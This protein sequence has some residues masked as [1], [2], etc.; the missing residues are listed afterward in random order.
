MVRVLTLNLW[1]PDAR[2]ADDARQIPF[3]DEILRRTAALP[4]VAAAGLTSDLPLGGSDSVLGF[5]I[6]GRPDA[7]P[8]EGTQSGFHQ[9]SPDYFRALGIP[10]SRGRSFGPRDAQQ[11]P[12]AVVVSETLAKRYWRGEDPIGRRISFGTNDKGE[13]YWMTVVGVAAD[14]RQKGLHADPRAES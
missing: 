2:Y 4:G 10:L 12:G 1:I 5:A 7:K 6:E 11:A 13:P 3:Y 8:D 14:V 9:V